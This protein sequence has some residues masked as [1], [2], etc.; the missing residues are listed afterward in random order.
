MRLF[1]VRF[2]VLAMIALVMGCS[3]PEEE[4]P[5]ENFQKLELLIK[6]MVQQGGALAEDLDTVAHYY[7]YLLTRKD[8]IR[9]HSR[10]SPYRFVGG[11]STNLPGQDSS[12]SS[13]ILLNSTPDRKKAEEQVVL[14]NFLDSVFA[15]FMRRNPM[16]VQIYSNS[17]MQV[18]RVYPTY[19]VRNIVD[20]NL[21]VT[22]FNF[23]YEADFDH[24]PS[25]GLVWI[26]EAYVD[27]AGKGWILSLVH[28]IYD[29]D[30]LFA[31]LGVDYTVSDIIQ[32][33]LDSVEGEFILV[34]S[35]GDIVAGKAEAIESLSM[36]PLKNHVYRETV[37][38]DYFRISDFNLFSSKSR[39]VR[40]M[41][42][43]FLLEKKDRFEFQEEA[44]LHWAICVPFVGVDWFLVEV[45][46]NH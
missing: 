44:N 30:E 15:A 42:Q 4:I 1:R 22:A 5:E 20:I 25:K 46:P 18:S 9:E 12:L 28:P 41:A 26:P 36:P 37:H 31:V 6:R 45:F 39:E 13:V 32:H 17:S 8:S 21:D 35:K 40:E 2:F 43:H 19:D 29:G 24:N 23:Y 11:I 7:E 33:Y 16:A 34:N 3:A 27:P 38:S 10:P 14:T